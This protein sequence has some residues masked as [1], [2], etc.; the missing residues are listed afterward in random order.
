MWIVSSSSPSITAS[1]SEEELPESYSITFELP[2]ELD[3]PDRSPPIAA[4]HKELDTLLGDSGTLELLGGLLKRPLRDMKPPRD[5][6]MGEDSGEDSASVEWCRLVAAREKSNPLER[7][8]KTEAADG[9]VAEVSGFGDTGMR[10]E[11][12]AVLVLVTSLGGICRLR[13]RG[14]TAGLFGVTG[15]D[16]TPESSLEE[17]LL[18]TKDGDG[19]SMDLKSWDDQGLLFGSRGPSAMLESLVSSQL[20]FSLSWAI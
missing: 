19:D 1:P 13:P 12:L 2:T 15:P 9:Y 5:P 16:A 10:L 18:S 8:G 14:A 6:I 17:R 7:R 3:K 11:R 4:P 20:S